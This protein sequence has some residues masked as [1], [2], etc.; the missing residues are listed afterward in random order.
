MD[1]C[2]NSPLL[3][4]PRQSGWWPWSCDR[5][6]LNPKI[7]HARQVDQENKFQGFSA[8]IS[9]AK[10]SENASSM[11]FFLHNPSDGT[12]GMGMGHMWYLN[13]TDLGILDHSRHMSPCF[14][15]WGHS[16]N[17]VLPQ[18]RHLYTW[19][20]ATVQ[21]FR[22]IQY[23]VGSLNIITFKKNNLDNHI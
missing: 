9:H 14:Q 22:F 11:R 6:Y 2:W 21:S 18:V 15:T 8:K 19:A 17:Q 4:D 1:H 20:A 5:T 12:K 3:R 7:I 13:G 16:A 23:S 10:Q